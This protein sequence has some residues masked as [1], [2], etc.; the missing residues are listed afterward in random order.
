MNRTSTQIF[1]ALPVMDER[2]NLPGF[3][4][5]L[6]RQSFQDFE[7]YICVNQPEDWWS[8]KEKR[9]VCEDNK[10]SLE[11]LNS[12]NDLKLEIIDR[13]SIGNGWKGKKKG[14]GWAR[15]IPMDRIAEMAT[16]S[17]II[18][19]IDADTAFEPEYLKSLVEFFHG[20][21]NAVA[22]AI[23]YYHKLTG[24]DEKDRNILRYEIYMRYYAINLWRI[25][26]PYAFTAIGSAIALPVKSYKTIGGIT[27]HNSG[28]DFYFLQKLRKF[29]QIATWNREKVYPEARFSDR[30]GF[31]TGPAMIRGRAGDWSGYPIFPYPLFDE[32]KKTYNLFDDL[33]EKD[34]PTPMDEF[35]GMKFG[36]VSIWQP[37]R[38][39]SKTKKQF[40]KACTHKIDAFRIIQFL[41]WENTKLQQ[42]DEENLIDFFNHHYSELIPTFSFEREKLNFAKSPIEELNEIRNL[43]LSIEEKY[44][45]SNA[46]KS[47]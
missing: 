46:N 37:L 15:K 26:N 24:D 34:V 27:P 9:H 1:I 8:L 7:L 22:I 2:E 6:R 43:L 4:E 19:S 42:S 12:L 32:I 44:Q 3:M 14:V 5:C 47:K 17:D 16:P 38:I 30:V 40:I 29:G 35:N 18:V 41:K 28:E 45:K 13:S 25:N 31:G 23:P 11:Y 21:K 36:D 10:S 20:N 33:F 39:N